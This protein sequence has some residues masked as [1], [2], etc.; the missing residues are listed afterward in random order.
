M[1][2]TGTLRGDSEQQRCSSCGFTAWK[3]AIFTDSPA[4][5]QR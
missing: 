3:R 1:V 4:D 5:H 2:Y